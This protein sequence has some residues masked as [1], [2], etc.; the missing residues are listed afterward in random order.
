M[1]ENHMVT[2]DPERDT[3]DPE[4][5]RQSALDSVIET[6]MLFGQYPQ[7]RTGTG[8]HTQTRRVEFDL[9]EW[10]AENMEPA[11][12][13][14][15]MVVHICNDENKD[16]QRDKAE[17]WIEEQL[18]GELVDSDMVMEKIDDLYNDDRETTC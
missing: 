11:D 4:P 5:Y 9:S 15:F 3:Y 10:V 16:L 7:P 8:W 6:I 17:K 12:L 1:E 13:A 18:R 14:H 2:G